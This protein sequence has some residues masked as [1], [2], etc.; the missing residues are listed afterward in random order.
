MNNQDIPHCETIHLSVSSTLKSREQLPG[1]ANEKYK[2][3]E[4]IHVNWTVS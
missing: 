4:D 3:G 2:E 1:K